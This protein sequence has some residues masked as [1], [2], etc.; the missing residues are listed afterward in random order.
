MRD[1][2]CFNGALQRIC[3]V[4]I[5]GSNEKY[6][7][8]EGELDMQNNIIEEYGMAVLYA[9]MGTVLLAALGNLLAVISAF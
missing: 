2:G 4:A 6:V 3:K 8:I 1:K 7:S 5:A 9:M